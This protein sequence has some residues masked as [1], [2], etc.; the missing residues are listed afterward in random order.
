MTPFGGVLWLSPTVQAR[1]LQAGWC[2]SKGAQARYDGLCT[3]DTCT[4]AAALPGLG[5]C[6][7]MQARKRTRTWRMRKMR[8]MGMTAWTDSKSRQ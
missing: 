3:S 4:N 5:S 1:P 7:R 8:T 6:W 2:P